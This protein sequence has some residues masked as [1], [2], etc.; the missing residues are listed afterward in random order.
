MSRYTD[1]VRILHVPEGRPHRYARPAQVLPFRRPACEAR[2]SRI[3]GWSLFAIV[4]SVVAA[5]MLII[6]LR[7]AAPA[8]DSMVRWPWW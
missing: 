1:N 3:V 8:V 7:S 5:S 6:A 2:L 4:A